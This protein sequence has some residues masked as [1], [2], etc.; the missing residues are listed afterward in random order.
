M[1]KIYTSR[2][3]RRGNFKPFFKNSQQ[4]QRKPQQQ[5]SWNIA[6]I[7]CIF[8][9]NRLNPF[10][11]FENEPA[12]PIDQQYSLDPMMQIPKI[13]ISAEKVFESVKII[14]EEM[15]NINVTMDEYNK[16]LEQDIITDDDFKSTITVDLYAV[17]RSY[18]MDKD[19]D[20]VCAMMKH[21]LHLDN[22]QYKGFSNA[23]INDDYILTIKEKL[24]ELNA[25]HA[26]TYRIQIT[27]SLPTKYFNIKSWITVNHDS[28]IIT[29]EVGKNFGIS[30]KYFDAVYI[31]QKTATIKLLERMICHIEN[32]WTSVLDKSNKDIH[33]TDEGYIALFGFGTNP[34]RLFN[35]AETDYDMEED[36]VEE[37]ERIV[38]IN[39]KH[40]LKYLIAVLKTT[41][42][43]TISLI[44][45]NNGLSAFYNFIHGFRNV[46]NNA[47]TSNNIKAISIFTF[48]NE[49]NF[50][51][52]WN[53]VMNLTMDDPNFTDMQGN[54][55]ISTEFKETNGKQLLN[56]ILMNYMFEGVQYTLHLKVATSKDGKTC[57]YTNLYKSNEF[58]GFITPYNMHHYNTELI[59]QLT[60]GDNAEIA[61]DTCDFVKLF[62]NFKKHAKI[63]P[64]TPEL[65]ALAVNK[66]ETARYVA[67]THA[68]INELVHDAIE[69][70]KYFNKYYSK[71]F[72][73][74]IKCNPDIYNILFDAAT[75]IEDRMLDTMDIFIDK[76]F[77]IA[78]CKMFTIISK[79]LINYV[80]YNDELRKQVKNSIE[81]IVGSSIKYK[82]SSDFPFVLSQLSSPPK[83]LKITP[84]G[85]EIRGYEENASFCNLIN[86][87]LPSTHVRLLKIFD[88]IITNM[89]EKDTKSLTA[90][91]D[92]AYR[93]VMNLIVLEQHGLFEKY[94]TENGF[95]IAEDVLLF[96]D[97]IVNALWYKSVFRIDIKRFIGSAVSQLMTH[98]ASIGLDEVF[99][100]FADNKAFSDIVTNHI[101]SYFK[102]F[103]TDI[104]EN[105]KN[106]IQNYIG[107]H[108]IY[109]Y[110]MQVCD[111]IVMDFINKQYI[112]KGVNIFSNTTVNKEVTNLMLNIIK[113]RFAQLCNGPYTRAIIDFVNVF[114]SEVCSAINERHMYLKTFKR[115][116]SNEEFINFLRNC[117]IVATQT[118]G[119]ECF[120]NDIVEID[121]TA[122][123]DKAA[124]QS[125]IE[126]VTL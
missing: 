82:Y 41:I 85:I 29:T 112:Q 34:A 118:I 108:Q 83:S 94:Y 57:V 56:K 20:T 45:S 25:G 111:G 5:N 103:A 113:M 62:K 40:M 46:N 68:R 86:L 95:T 36:E 106:C 87:R 123:I 74:S 70:L 50:L 61:D 59:R 76:S 39:K 126:K 124:V 65:E 105:D 44:N 3:P 14:I 15:F 84:L 52:L 96:N 58:K 48:F 79:A 67:L 7:P 21:D 122:T 120:R 110:S 121:F 71:I 13:V 54:L 97:A 23:Y 60:T 89:L 33:N 125:E 30:R 92:M 2:Q 63:N 115:E 19:Y 53:K 22:D 43:G 75:N 24:S 78:Q 49:T 47:T 16:M 64:A 107:L 6:N 26:L 12:V 100:Y 99:T 91:D 117:I 28:K 35:V 1:S 38:N 109:H 51:G 18:Q 77:K 42:R 11:V 31:E 32:I 119:M 10:T 81:S 88:D 72:N 101:M 4:Q 98:H 116:I 114:V 104:L 69:F 93:I 27:S 102:E 66:D 73:Y 90:G 37:L 8:Y 17:Y 55:I 9:G 80:Y